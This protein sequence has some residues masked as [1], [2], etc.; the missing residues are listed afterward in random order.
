M[1]YEDF[2]ME[3]VEHSV[4]CLSSSSLFQVRATAWPSSSRKVL[5]CYYISRIHRQT[6]GK[7]W[8]QG[9]NKEYW[10]TITLFFVQFPRRMKTLSEAAAG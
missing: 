10:N 1:F 6:S 4:E 5:E 2:G 9:G 7:E 8:R 3:K